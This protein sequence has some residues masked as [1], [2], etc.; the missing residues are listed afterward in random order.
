MKAIVYTQNGPP[1]VLQLRELAKPEPRED[2]VLVKV[3]AASPNALDYRR[4]EVVS[5]GPHQ[6]MGR[7]EE[8]EK[9]HL[10][11]RREA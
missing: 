3:H 10:L 5:P 1:N 9:G 2:Q 4:F 11:L 6:A 8:R 7:L